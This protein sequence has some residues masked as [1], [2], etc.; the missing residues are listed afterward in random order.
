MNIQQPNPSQFSQP[1]PQAVNT[2]TALNK[3]SPKRK[4]FNIFLLV[5]LVL[6][7]LVPT[8]IFQSIGGLF[9]SNDVFVDKGL[10]VYVIFAPDSVNNNAIDQQVSKIMTRDSDC[11]SC[12]FP[13]LR[14]DRIYV[15]PQSK[16]AELK[17]EFKSGK[18][19]LEAKLYVITNSLGTVD[20]LNNSFLRK[21][22][23]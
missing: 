19:G 14:S 10:Q 5:L 13:Q 21:K 12:I 22:S 7:F 2:Q 4:A 3:L 23:L 11:N 18:S 16:K 6:M 17:N 9:S 20:E 1:V 15:L 8:G